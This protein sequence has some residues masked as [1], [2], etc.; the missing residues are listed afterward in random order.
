M[1]LG[2]SGILVGFTFKLNHLMGAEPI[3][4]TGVFAAVLGLLLSV[5]DI[6]KR[7]NA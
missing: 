3:F 6:W 7:R 2:L 4:N 1:L 5:R